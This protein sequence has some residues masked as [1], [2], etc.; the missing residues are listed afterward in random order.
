MKTRIHIVLDQAEKARLSDAARR[1]GKSLS[2]WIR[3]A[4]REKAEAADARAL[5]TREDLER[6]FEQV[7]VWEAESESQPESQPESPPEPE[8]DWEAH[9][10]VIASSRRAGSSPS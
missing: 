10:Q 2:A 1:A 9:R 6:F 5:S 8:P 7:D 4:A 3:Q